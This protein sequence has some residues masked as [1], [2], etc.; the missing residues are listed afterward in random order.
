MDYKQKIKSITEKLPERTRLVAV[1]KYHPSEEIQKAYDAGCRIF[2]ES[3]VQEVR[4]K[5]LVLPGDIE[6]HF[7]GHLQT[8]KVKYIAPFISMIHAIDTPHL[9]QEVEKQAS[10]H[11][12]TIPCLLQLHVAKEETKFGFT[13]EECMDFLQKG[14][15]MQMPHVRISGI[16]C[17][18]TNTDNEDQIRSE[19]RLAHEFFMKAKETI[20]RDK[21]YFCECSMGM[22]N[23]WE[24]AV[25]EG[26]TLIRVGTAIFGPR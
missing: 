15:W 1:S 6:W 20:F 13:T 12:R 8:N 26:S 16:M 3:H 14:E 17:M 25:D 9:L 11:N 5:Q 10:K 4:E 7:I 19:F 24:I 21:D 23:D 18:A 2:G 22:S